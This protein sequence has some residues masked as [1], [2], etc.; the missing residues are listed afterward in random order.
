[1]ARMRFGAMAAA[2]VCALAALA[3]GGCQKEAPA[4]APPPASGAAAPL[5]IL[6]LAPNLTEIL[7]AMGLGDRVVGRSTYCAYP[8]EAAALP[9][10]GD[11]LQLNLE[12]V[13][14]LKPTV[15]F[16]ITRRDDVPRRLEAVGVR[17]VAL[18]SDHMSEMLQSVATIGRETG[19]EADAQ[20]LLDHIQVGLM[21][22][23]ARVKGLPRPKVL[24]AFP[25]TIGSPQMMVAGRGTFVDELLDVAGAANAYPKTADWPTLSPQAVIGLGPEVVIVNATAEDAA[26]DRLE[27]VRRAWANW[28][29]VPAVKAGRVHVLT[30][31]FLTIPGPRVVQAAAVLAEAIHPELRGATPE[32]ARP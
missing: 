11:T 13:V 22:V 20:M 15:A 1:M 21:R 16:L 23:R 17:A 25:M 6:S 26:P 18:R 28:A 14:A 24:F 31:T 10:V 2:V 3:A 7:F 9:A 19:H 29:S 12:R 4:P 32:G 27:A 30:E 8:P 5:R